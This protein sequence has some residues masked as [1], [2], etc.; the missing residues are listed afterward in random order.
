M[1]SMPRPDERAHSLFSRKVDDVTYRW[2]DC[3]AEE[4][5]LV[6]RRSRRESFSGRSD[7]E[8]S[9]PFAVHKT[10]P[11]DIALYGL[12]V[13]RPFALALLIFTALSGS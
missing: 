3:G 13:T 11:F 10:K 2:D 8:Q 12:G 4:M 7:H 6:P 9:E 1:R 5:R